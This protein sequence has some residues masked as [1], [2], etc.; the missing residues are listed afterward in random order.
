MNADKGARK[1]DAT[2]GHKGHKE[3]LG[4]RVGE[5]FRSNAANGIDGGVADGGRRLHVRPLEAETAEV[6]I[7]PS[8]GLPRIHYPKPASNVHAA[9]H[10]NGGR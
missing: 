4:W 5:R 7:Y 6:G 1:S 8:G 2:K 10:P 3:L 9:A